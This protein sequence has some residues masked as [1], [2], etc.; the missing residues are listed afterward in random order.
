MCLIKSQLECFLP[1]TI[2][3]D[4]TNNYSISTFNVT[5][6]S[7]CK[8]VL[9]NLKSFLHRQR[10]SRLYCH[11]FQP[12]LEY[13]RYTFIM[14]PHFIFSSQL[15]LMKPHIPDCPTRVATKLQK[16]HQRDTYSCRSVQQDRSCKRR[17]F[18]LHPNQQ[19]HWRHSTERIS[20]R[21][22]LSTTSV[23]RLQHSCPFDARAYKAF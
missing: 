21:T 9:R 8:N 3:C 17:H 19:S 2:L 6:S 22:T 12:N 14:Y 5:L 23:P 18:L 16:I 11:V 13:S 20:V 1:Y 7:G 15:L 10:C 4:N